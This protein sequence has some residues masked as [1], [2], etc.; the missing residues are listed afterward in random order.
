MTR[1]ILALACAAT[2]GLGAPT[3][4]WSQYGQPLDDAELDAARGGLMTPMGFEIGFGASVRTFVDGQL[5]LET[6][7]TWTQQGVNT[8]RVF[9]A[10]LAPGVNIGWG[11]G[12]PSLNGGDTRIIHDLTQDRIAS[13][14]INTASDRNI[15]QDTDITL[16]LPQLPQLQQ[17]MAIDRVSAALQSAL[18]FAL[19][20]NAGR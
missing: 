14:V 8:E 6:R 9:E 15:R 12:L 11:E 10:P 3:A 18:G 2:L 19:S 7:L 17:Q 20:E 4:A 5:A 13:L 1:R 16:R